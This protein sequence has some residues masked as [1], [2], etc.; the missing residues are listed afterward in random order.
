[1]SSP[2]LETSVAPRQ[3]MNQFGPGRVVK[4]GKIHWVV[5]LT[6]VNGLG[7]S[8]IQLSHLNYLEISTI[9]SGLESTLRTMMQKSPG[10]YSV[11]NKAASFLRSIYLE[12]R[13]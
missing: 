2:N 8:M 4:E 6:W 12:R 13:T 7:A 10:L 9:D 11:F 1:M 5:G 3:G